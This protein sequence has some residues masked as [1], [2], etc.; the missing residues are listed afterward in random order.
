MIVPASFDWS[1]YLTLAEELE[2][3]VDEASLRSALSRA[4]YYV[5]HLALKRAE[6][7]GFEVRPGEGTHTQLWRLFSG[8]SE[9]ACQKLAQMAGRLKDKRERADYSPAFMRLKEEVTPS[10]EDA[11]EFARML[12]SLAPRHPSPQSIRQ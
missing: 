10:L 2:M 9:T 12:N 7:N 1:A 4:Y 11:R 5:Y 6:A 8:S 3:R